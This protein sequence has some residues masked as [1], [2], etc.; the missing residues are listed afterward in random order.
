MEDDSSDYDS[1][2]EGESSSLEQPEDDSMT[3]SVKSREAIDKINKQVANNIIMKIKGKEEI[4][5][6]QK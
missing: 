5:E 1:E 4:A 3:D 6:K 2:A